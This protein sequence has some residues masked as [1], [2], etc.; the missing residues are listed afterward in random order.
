[1][2]DVETGVMKRLA[3]R[4]RPLGYWFS[5]DGAR[6]AYTTSKGA[7]RNTQQPYFDIVLLDVA[8][9]RSWT[10]ASNVK[11]DYGISVSWSPD[12]Q[13][14]AYT[15]AGQ[16]AEGECFLVDALG[17]VQRAT[18]VKHPS[19]A[20]DPRIVLCGCR[21]ALEGRHRDTGRAARSAA[22]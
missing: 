7:A 19:F 5:P 18:D 13:R 21:R 8:D 2:I 16:Q 20:D 14:I 22:A 9:G 4:V 10:I 1:L 11:M 6:I 17:H 3:V 12:G 15:D